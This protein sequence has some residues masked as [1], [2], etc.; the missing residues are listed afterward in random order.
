MRNNFPKSKEML[1]SKPAW[2]KWYYGNKDKA[3]A[4]QKKYYESKKGVYQESRI[5]ARKDIIEAHGGKCVC[6]GEHR[7]QFLTLNKETKHLFCMNCVWVRR[8]GGICP[9]EEEANEALGP[10]II[11]ES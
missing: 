6:C 7:W 4:S 11:G 3:K 1:T 9:H 2:H 10:A 8:R 5:Q